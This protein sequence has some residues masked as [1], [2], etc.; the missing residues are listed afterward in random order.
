MIPKLNLEKSA[1][2]IAVFIAFSCSDQV[3]PVRS[4]RINSSDNTASASSA[5]R[6]ENANTFNVSVGAPIEYSKGERWIDNYVKDASQ[7]KTYTIKAN[8][9]NKIL[10]SKNCVGI[11]LVYAIDFQNK[12]HILPIG[13]DGNGKRITSKQVYTQNGDIKWKTAQCWIAN[14]TGSVS[15]HFFGQNTFQRLW[16]NGNVDV[17]T[18]LAIDDTNNPQLLLTAV[19]PTNSGGRVAAKSNFEDASAACPPACPK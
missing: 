12:L 19:T 2:A 13:V 7:S 15:S 5:A 9:L 18:T 4:E 3:T 10:S 14:Y 17:L 11:S 1:A 6:A 8:A 16:A